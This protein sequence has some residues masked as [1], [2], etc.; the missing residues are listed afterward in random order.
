MAVV[1]DRKTSLAG[2]LKGKGRFSVRIMK[3]RINVIGRCFMIVDE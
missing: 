1:P 3:R 2:Y